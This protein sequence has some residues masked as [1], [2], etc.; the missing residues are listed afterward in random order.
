MHD[1]PDPRG[2]MKE[3][4][5]HLARRYFSMLNMDPGALTTRRDGNAMPRQSRETP[6]WVHVLLFAVTLA[7]TTLAGA[8]ERG[9]L[10]LSIASGLPFS[11]TIMTILLSHEMGHYLAARRFHVKA[12]L[13]YF[14]PFPSIIGTMGAVIKIK[15]PIHDKRALLYIGAMGPIIGFILSLAAS[16]IGLYLS[17]VKPL[18][19]GGGMN[20]PIFGDSALFK[21]LTFLIHGRIPGGHDIYLSSF[22]WAGWIG[23]L[24]TS[25]NLMPMGQLDGSHVLYA[26]IGRKQLYFGWAVF[27]GLAALSFIWPGW[28]VWIL[29]ALLFLM[30]GH[31]PVPQSAPLTLGEKL[32]G[33]ACI[34]IFFLTFIPVP[35]DFI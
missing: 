27:F 23:F 14:I 30:I 29:M 10:L 34:I 7:S 24:V 21:M 3:K 22:A 26:L 33:W 15:S 35:V 13:P 20:I 11:L 1:I 6:A 2:G 25:L 31:P 28:V 16:I 8:Q 5:D 17:E 32:L 9:S 19:S 4:L 18:P 12:T